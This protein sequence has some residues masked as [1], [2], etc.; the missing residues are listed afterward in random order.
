M[1]TPLVQSCP[2]TSF[3]TEDNQEACGWRVDADWLKA[4]LAETSCCSARAMPN[5]GNRCSPIRA[6][7]R[8]GQRVEIAFADD[9]DTSAA[10]DAVPLTV[11]NQ[12]RRTLLV[13]VYAIDAFRY[14]V[15]KQKEVDD[16]RTSTAWC[17]TEQKLTTTEPPIRRARRRTPDLLMPKDPGT[18]VVDPSVTYLGAAL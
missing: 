6:R 13:K 11:D 2:S 16:D 3:A 8:A 15:E 4:V 12:E 1:T 18:W 7:R 17:R 10:N 9:A 5:A 14:H